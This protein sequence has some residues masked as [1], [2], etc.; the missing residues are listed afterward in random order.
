[1]RSPRRITAT[2]TRVIVLSP[3]PEPVN[4]RELDD[5]VT[6]LDRVAVIAVVGGV[7]VVPVVEATVVDEEV[8]DVRPV[9]VMLQLPSESMFSQ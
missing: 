6:T 3:G 9:T 1:M 8:V 5:A 4:A 2:P 7:G